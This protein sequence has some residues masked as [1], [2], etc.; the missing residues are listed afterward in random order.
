MIITEI[1]SE[2]L[3]RTTSSEGKRIRQIES[4]I[5]LD[6]AIDSN[7]C[8]YH[9]EETDEYPPEPEPTADELVEILLGGEPA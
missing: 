7:P 5:I 4:G 2:N 3:V 1:I 9:Y 8:P 6:S